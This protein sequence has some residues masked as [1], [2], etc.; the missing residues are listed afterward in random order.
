MG[1]ADAE[2]V[3][4]VGVRGVGRVGG[5]DVRVEASGEW[6]ECAGVGAG[7]IA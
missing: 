5:S 1:V 7:P 4:W 6:L 2:G 3:L